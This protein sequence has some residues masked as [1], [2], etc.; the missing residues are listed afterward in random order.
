MFLDFTFL[1]SLVCWLVL[2]VQLYIDLYWDGLFHFFSVRLLCD[3]GLIIRRHAWYFTLQ[4][5]QDLTQ[6]RST[7]MWDLGRYKNRCLIRLHRELL[8]GDCERDGLRSETVGSK[9]LLLIW[10]CRQVL[11][12]LLLLFTGTRQVTWAWL[13][14]I[15]GLVV[16]TSLTSVQ[17]ALLLLL[18]LFLNVDPVDCSCLTHRLYY[19]LG[20]SSSSLLLVKW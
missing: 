19:G 17:I 7:L 2:L 20:L 9:L 4:F 15:T 5:I 12:L 18:L 16:P 10:S 8:L 14:I 6:A 13:I 3:F 1:L 11:L